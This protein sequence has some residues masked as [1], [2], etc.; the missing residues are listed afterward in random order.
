M[1]IVKMNL[2]STNQNKAERVLRFLLSLVLI[3]APFLISTTLY[4]LTLSMVGFVLL[5]NA[6]SGACMIY[7]VL[8][9]NTCEV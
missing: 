8:G 2:L 9:V 6:L 5:F 1:R 7:K 4:P 3:P